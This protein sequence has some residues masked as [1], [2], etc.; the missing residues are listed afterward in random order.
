MGHDKRVWPSN[1]LG[2]FS[3]SSAYSLLCDFDRL[4]A[5]PVWE[6]LWVAVMPERARL[7]VWKLLNRKLLTRWGLGDPY[8][9]FCA[10]V[11]ETDMHALRDCPRS[12]EIWLHLVP[13]H[14]RA[15]FFMGA[16]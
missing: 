4:F 12:A 13:S 9:P 1:R 5:D 6:A 11:E 15:I 8:C 16:L 14:H 7:F 10:G 3:V 2:E